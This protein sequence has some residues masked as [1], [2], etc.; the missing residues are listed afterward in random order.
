MS[1]IGMLVDLVLDVTGLT[2]TV[3]EL[4]SLPAQ[5]QPQEPEDIIRTALLLRQL[6]PADLIPLILDYA[7]LWYP[8]A[9]A[10]TSHTASI[11][12]AA[13]H[14]IQASLLIPA[15]IPHKAIRRIR[16]TTVSRDQ[17]WSSYRED[18]GTYRGSWTWFEAGVAGLTDES[19]D[20]HSNVPVIQSTL[21]APQNEINQ[22]STRML[23]PA[24][25]EF[26][27]MRPEFYKYGAKR[28]ITNIHAGRN[29]K[30]HV[31]EWDADH[32]DEDV[33]RMMREIK[34]GC[35]VDVAA[36]ARF[37]GW[38]NDVKSIKIEAECAVVRKM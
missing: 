17:G 15:Y 25:R 9:E 8:V 14:R 6:L 2:S 38:C 29:Y 32:E 36:C 26:E 37:G 22:H 35:C 16:F 20:P 21:L 24:R 19:P 18:Q 13:S 4:S 27:L 33:R 1:L 5:I 3:P 30:T 7:Q 28:I 10:A 34:A 31:V 23:D 12:E 11:S